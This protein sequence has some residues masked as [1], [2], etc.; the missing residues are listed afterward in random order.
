MDLLFLGGQDYTRYGE[1]GTIRS[2][3]Y[4]GGTALKPYTEQVSLFFPE[5]NCEFD[6]LR[7]TN[8]EH[9]D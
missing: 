5:R 1:K 8:L 7:V 3:F 9:N 6:I 2:L 4:E